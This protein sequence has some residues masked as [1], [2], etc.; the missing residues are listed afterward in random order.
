MVGSSQPYPSNAMKN[1]LL[2]CLALGLC[3]HSLRAED[4]LNDQLRRAAEKLKNEFAKVKDQGEVKGREW[5]KKAKDHLTTSREEYL[6]QSSTALIR[7]KADIDVLKE[8]VGREYFKTRVLALDQHHAFALK[9]LETLNAVTDETQFRARQKSFDKTL[10]TLEAA[11]E[12][13]QEEA[14]L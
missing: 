3:L 10:W 14:G 13:A 9:E 1:P 6:Q 12:Q 5:Y 8:Q 7:W 11:V 4:S 2:I